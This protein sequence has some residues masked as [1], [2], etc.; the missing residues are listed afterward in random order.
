VTREEA[1]LKEAE[2]RSAHWRRWGPYLAE[3]Q[4]GTVR[5]DYSPHGTAWDF[6]PHDHAR[7]RAYR[8]GEDGLRGITD[9]HG[10]LCFALA[11]WHGHEPILKDLLFWLTG[12]AGNHGRPR[13]DRGRA[14]LARGALALLRGRTRAALHRERDQYGA[15][16]A[17]AE[18]G[19]LRE[20]RHRP[21]R[22]RGGAGRRQP[23]RGRHEGGRVSSLDARARREP[24]NTLAAREHADSGRP[25]RAGGR[26]HVYPAPGRGGRVLRDR[27]PQGPVGR[28]QERHAT[29]LRRAALVQAVLPL[30]RP[31]LARGRPGVA[32]APARAV[33]RAEP[34]VAPPLQRGRR[35]DAGQVG[36]PVVRGVG[37]RVPH[38]S[39]RADRPRLREGATRPVPARVVHASERAASGVRVG[40]R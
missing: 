22:G 24:D 29:G 4:W 1:R 11:L 14:P 34:R 8:W 36:V 9:N 19:A 3:R 17:G 26:Q 7:S 25:V 35:L 10:R 13:R 20:G 28:R 23:G 15:P 12:P 32:A 27:D 31:A 37:S 38:D 30:R 2:E 40:A 21:L 6:F 16:V 39:A 18:S 5:E 33:A